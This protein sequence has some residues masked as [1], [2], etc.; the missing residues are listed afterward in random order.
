MQLKKAIEQAGVTVQGDIEEIDSEMESHL[1]QLQEG[2]TA[3]GVTEYTHSHTTSND[4]TD[5]YPD[6]DSS[7]SDNDDLL[8]T[9]TELMNRMKCNDTT[10]V[11]NNTTAPD[12]NTVLLG[13]VRSGRELS[14][15]TSLVHTTTCIKCD[16]NNTVDVREKLSPCFRKSK[17]NEGVVS[18]S[19]P[20]TDSQG[21]HTTNTKDQYYVTTRTNISNKSLSGSYNEKPLNTNSSEGNE[22]VSVVVSEPAQLQCSMS[23]SEGRLNQQD[24]ET[25]SRYTC[26]VERDRA[27]LLGS[28]RRRGRDKKEESMMTDRGS[29]CL[30]YNH[31]MEQQTDNN[32]IG[33]SHTPTDSSNSM[34]SSTYPL[35]TTTERN[36]SCVMDVENP[37]D[38]CEK[39]RHKELPPQQQSHEVINDLTGTGVGNRNTQEI[40]ND[41]TCT[42]LQNRNDSL[43]KSDPSCDNVSDSG[44]CITEC[45]S[46]FT[47]GAS[48]ACDTQSL[49]QS[50]TSLSPHNSVI[51]I[52]QSF[53]NTN[54]AS[55]DS[56]TSLSVLQPVSVFREL[57]PPKINKL[58][59]DIT[60]LISYV[61]N[62]CHGA[63]NFEFGEPI[64]SQQA[65]EERREK[66]LPKLEE[67]FKGLLHIF[68]CRM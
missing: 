53:N 63:C 58:N 39:I 41:S 44:R 19:P 61:S 15:D 56:V 55:G 27:D 54:E 52:P 5:F 67:L 59:L 49:S 13:G 65:A 7:D 3:E 17:S 9:A 21:E 29:V 64:L 4:M 62:V 16:K 10:K 25:Q 46:C 42:S 40:L 47:G 51:T 66:L 6:L 34:I 48:V 37:G 12:A 14:A 22:A 60:T 11:C 43:F 38:L 2:F 30:N 18:D 45:T 26:S 23:V 57:S 50:S 20:I 36:S 8:L 31:Q 24:K 32:L 35:S 1:V 68:V 33:H 28:G